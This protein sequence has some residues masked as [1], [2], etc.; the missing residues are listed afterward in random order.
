MRDEGWQGSE[1]EKEE[2]LSRGHQKLPYVVHGSDCEFTALLPHPDDEG[3][4][5]GT[6]DR[7]RDVL[8]Q[9]R[10]KTE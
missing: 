2:M 7:S 6:A 10:K 8:Y 1:D 4:A 9:N 3:E 5:E